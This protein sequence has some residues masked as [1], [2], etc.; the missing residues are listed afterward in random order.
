MGSA[1]KVHLPVL[2]LSDIL[3][4]KSIA[5]DQNEVNAAFYLHFMQKMI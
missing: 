3:S 4:F 1:M 5:Q 2:I